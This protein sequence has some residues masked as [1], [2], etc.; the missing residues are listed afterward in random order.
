MIKTV[1]VIGFKL[2][3]FSPVWCL[4]REEQDSINAQ[5]CYI[6][7]SENIFFEKTS[8][9]YESTCIFLVDYYGGNGIGTNNG[10]GRS[11]IIG[12]YL[13][14]GI[15][16]T[17]LVDKKN[18]ILHTSGAYFL[19][20][21]VVEV[22]NYQLY[23]NVLPNGIIK[24]LSL[25]DIGESAVTANFSNPTKIFNKKEKIS[26]L[27]RENTLRIGHFLR[28]PY[29]KSD[30]SL[31]AEDYERVKVNNIYLSKL[32]DVKALFKQL[33]IKASKQM[34]F[35]LVNGIAH[36]AM[37]QSN[38]TI[39]GRWLDLSN[40]TVVPHNYEYQ[41]GKGNVLFTK[42]WEH[43]RNYLK[44]L[45]YTYNKVN[46]QS[47]DIQTYMDLFNSVFKKSCFSE[48]LSL[49]GFYPAKN[50][51]SGLVQTNIVNWYLKSIFNPREIIHGL[52]KKNYNN[53]LLIDFITTIFT[54]AVSNNNALFSL[55][56]TKDAYSVLISLTR[57][58]KRAFFSK[59]LYLSSI[60]EKA[61]ELAWSDELKGY[62]CKR[63][64]DLSNWFFNS[65]NIIFYG[66]SMIISLDS[67]CIHVNIQNEKQKFLLDNNLI[68]YLNLLDSRH[69]H[70]GFSQLKEEVITCIE[71]LIFL[72]S[73]TK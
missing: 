10:S 59:A 26:L 68:T 60:Y 43:C 30:L 72:I 7:D 6:L 23:C 8:V 45:I 61:R 21:G 54:Q 49:L 3:K 31:H 37:T 2:K 65:S 46:H 28:A 57:L 20:D 56:E 34:A 70:M 50:K 44:E 22:F 9:N 36:G 38:I 19:Y 48:S 32:Y 4:E 67:D 63:F 73:Q 53:S 66:T 71:Y 69:F 5:C 51:D 35:S 18:D 40:T 58:I 27:I 13:V 42:E 62:D 14:K 29:L 25:I 64:G 52:P 11:G 33:A 1:K 12:N 47:I 55:F 39:D 16:Q 24:H 41:A 15:G 17:P